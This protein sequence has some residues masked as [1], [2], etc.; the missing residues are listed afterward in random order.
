MLSLPDPVLTA[1]AIA[2]AAAAAVVSVGVLL[3]WLRKGADFKAKRTERRMQREIEEGIYERAVPYLI[4]HERLAEA[5]E[6]LEKRGK[7][8]QAAQLFERVGDTKRAASIYAG[9]GEGDMAALVLKEA[10]EYHAAGDMYAEAG[11]WDSAAEMYAEAGAKHEAASAYRQAGKLAEAA[12]LLAEVDEHNAALVIFEDL[13]LHAEV[14]TSQQ[15]LGNH[16]AAARAWLAAGEVERAAETM[17]GAGEAATGSRLIAEWAELGGHHEIAAQKW[18]AIGEEEKAIEAYVQAGRNEQAA[19]L[20]VRRGDKA[21]AADAL[22]AAEQF[23]E[24]AEIYVSLTR[25]KEAASAYY[26]AGNVSK[27]VHYLQVCQ[28][29]LTMARV[30]LAYQLVKEAKDA[31]KSVRRGT[32]SYRDAMGLLAQLEMRDGN[33]QEAFRVYEDLVEQAIAGQHVDPETRQWI[34]EMVDILFA[35]DKTQEGMQWLRRLEELNLMTPEIRQQLAELAPAQQS[36]SPQAHRVSLQQL[37]C[38]LVMPQ[39]ERYEFIAKIGQGGNGVIYKALD[40]ML[41]REI[42]IKM[43]GSSSLPSVTARKF[44]LREAQTAAQLNHPNIVTI[45][46]MGEIEQQPYI[47]MEYVNGENLA[48][49]VER[50]TLP[51][52]ADQLGP[53]VDQLCDAM[54]YAHDRGVVHRDIKLENVMINLDGDVKLMDFGLAK[55]MHGIPDQTVVI[56]GTPAYMSPEQIVGTGVDHRTD[57][58]ALGVMIY[59]LMAGDWPYSDGNILAHHRFTPLP[60]PCAVNPSLPAVFRDLI[61][62]CMSKDKDERFESAREVSTMF[63]QVFGLG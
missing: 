8:E 18:E 31:L 10:K 62:G 58:Y 7:L 37:S 24:A 55:A 11:R 36:E 26:K 17:A 25:F 47:A 3:W 54:T 1:N 42:V 38:A 33:P 28:D 52:P 16:E 44:F 63:R 2:I 49:L 39:H 59:L 41:A 13:E 57:I 15:A 29:F 53:I 9:A 46:D 19:R 34:L 22:M 21:G 60:D 27:A 35:H 4:E 30:F 14:A 51:M 45:F 61:K 5:A 43:I 40:Q 23:S 20:L 50:G 32:E 56:S 48:D 6:L 12:K